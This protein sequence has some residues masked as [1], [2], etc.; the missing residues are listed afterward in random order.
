[1]I[2]TNEQIEGRVMAKDEH[3]TPD[4]YSIQKGRTID[5]KN[6]KKIDIDIE[7]MRCK[8]SKS[9]TEIGKHRHRHRIEKCDIHSSLFYTYRYRITYRSVITV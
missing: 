6:M 9:T 1:M 7:I 5:G 8:K 2:V 3:S 4:L